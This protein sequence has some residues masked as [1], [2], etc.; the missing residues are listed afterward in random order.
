MFTWSAVTFVASRTQSCSYRNS[1]PGASLSRKGTPVFTRS[2][3]PCTRS[4]FVSFRKTHRK[5]TMKSSLVARASCSFNP[6]HVVPICRIEHSFWREQRDISGLPPAVLA[7]HM[8]R[9]RCSAYCTGM[10]FRVE[11]YHCSAAQRPM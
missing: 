2:R 3:L 4:H 7:D 9:K 8:A 11:E 1:S 5:P 6:H 10:R